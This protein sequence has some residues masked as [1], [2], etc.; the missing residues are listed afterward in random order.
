MAEGDGVG[1]LVSKFELLVGEVLGVRELAGLS[2]EISVES[3]VGIP[4]EGDGVDIWFF[5]G[6]IDEG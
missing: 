6:N 4:D 1:K 5:D 2:L 3:T